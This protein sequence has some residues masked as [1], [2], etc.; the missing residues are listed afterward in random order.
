MF[1]L[2]SSRLALILALCVPALACGGTP[3]EVAQEE[4]AAESEA[5]LNARTARFE[6]FVGFD[7]K[8]Y[9]ELIAGNGKNV[10]RSE[11]Y[12]SH[13]NAE[14]GIE[15]L[16]RVG[17]DASAYRIKEAKNGEFYFNVV[18][19]NGETVSSSELYGT[20]SNAQRG[21]R[22]AR[23]LL[24]ALG[25]PVTAPAPKTPR[26]ELYRDAQNKARFRLRAANGE[27]VL[28]S[29]AYASK[30]SAHNGIASVV[31]NGQDS[32]RFDLIEGDEGSVRIRLLALNGAI[33]AHGESYASRF[34]AE[35]A[36]ARIGELLADG[37]PVVEQ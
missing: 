29:Q 36:V 25:H 5:E 17:Q 8:S 16:M 3:E 23:A 31:E 19:K 34:N 20:A 14:R 37:V 21:A 24:V 2:Q 32:L 9:F 27:L 4:A 26:F 30:A 11:G 12:A 15:G 22:T 10:L 1:T 28:S 18:A 35:R 33:V 7:G 13:S 6:T